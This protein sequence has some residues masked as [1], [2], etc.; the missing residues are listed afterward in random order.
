MSVSCHDLFSDALYRPYQ[1]ARAQLEHYAAVIPSHNEIARLPDMSPEDFHASWTDKPFILESPVKDWPAF[2]DW[3]TE[4]LLARYA[5]THF[6]AEAVDWP[7]RTYVDYMK[8]CRD[9]ESPLYLFDHR[10]VEKMDLD[11]SSLQGDYWPPKCFG[12]DLFSVLDSQRPDCRWLIVGPARSGSTFHKDPNATS[13][14]NAVLRGSK[15]W[16]LF[17]H[18]TPSSPLPPGVVLSSDSSEITSPLSIAEYLLT[19]HEQARATPGCHEGICRAGE[20]LHVPSGWLHL[21]LNL[22]ETVAITQNFI[23]RNRERIADV[24]DFL[25]EKP[26]QA[27][28]FKEDVPDPYQLWVRRLG[29]VDP[30]SLQEGLAITRGR[31]G[32][33]KTKWE[34]ITGNAGNANEGSGTF[35]FGFSSDGEDE[36]P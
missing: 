9:E 36:I 15:Y 33:K 23:P 24:L 29:E 1:C 7:L 14:W 30:D 12:V 28:G 31:A 10:F 5:D 25:R 2:Q 32:R 3:S 27:S 11:V 4:C 19:F 17:P 16:I 18:P 22:E 8:D 26:D 35:S 20:V 13:A 21:V 34:N 6:R